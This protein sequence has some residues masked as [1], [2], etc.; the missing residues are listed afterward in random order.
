MCCVLHASCII[1]GVC[2]CDVYCMRCVLYHVPAVCVL[3]AACREKFYE[4]K[5]KQQQE[6]LRHLHDERQRLIGIKGE[7]QDLGWACRDL[8]VRPPAPPLAVLPPPSPA[9]RH[10]A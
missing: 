5:L 4:A 6:E 1:F 7:I 3:C 8:Q 10:R 2:V 9:A